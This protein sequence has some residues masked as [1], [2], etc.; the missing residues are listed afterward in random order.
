MTLISA[1]KKKKDIKWE[2][3]V[4]FPYMRNQLYVNNNNKSNPL[5]L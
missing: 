4:M 3:T 2:E 5:M 1:S